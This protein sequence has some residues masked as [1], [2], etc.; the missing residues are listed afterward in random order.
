[1]KNRVLFQKREHDRQ[2]ALGIEHPATMESWMTPRPK[3]KIEDVAIA[4]Q[5][6]HANLPLALQPVQESWVQAV[7]PE[8]AAEEAVAEDVLEIAEDVDCGDGWAIVESSVEKIAEEEVVDPDVVAAAKAKIAGMLKKFEG[9]QLRDKRGSSIHKANAVE[10]EAEIKAEPK[11]EPKSEPVIPFMDV[12]QSDEE[13]QFDF[14][15]VAGYLRE[16]EAR[17]EDEIW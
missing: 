4:L 16:L 13:N 9:L 14:E 17:N 15:G 6:M 3:A 8:P 12:N 2:Q 10:V 1:M 11:S 7:L 5:E